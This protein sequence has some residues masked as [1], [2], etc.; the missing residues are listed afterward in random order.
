MLSL[1]SKTQLTIIPIE[2]PARNEIKAPIIRIKLK[3]IN[4]QIGNVEKG[5]FDTSQI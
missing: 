4:D 5:L 1:N 2:A 3:V